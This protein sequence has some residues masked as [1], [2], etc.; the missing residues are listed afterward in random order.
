MAVLNPDARITVAKI[1]I[2]NQK[3][4]VGKTTTSLNLA[5]ALCRHGQTPLA[6]DLDPQAHLSA[7]AG[8]QVDNAEDSIYGF[9]NAQ[10]SLQELVRETHGG[11]HLIPAHV[12]LSKVDS[13]PGKGPQ[14]LHRLNSAI[15]RENLNTGR[16]IVIDC[17]PIL[18]M[19]SLNAIFA[20]D[21]ILVPVS[22]DWL[23]VKG[24]IQVDRTMRA[25]E[26]HVF[27][28]RLLRR[29]V[30]TRFDGRRRMSHAIYA[31]IRERFGD[32]LCDTKIS[33]NVSVAESPA[34]NEDVF[35]HA[36]GSRGAQDYDALH[37]ELQAA[38]FLS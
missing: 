35:A 12:E 18:G 33:E 36:P 13:Q 32:E 3:G 21:R 9:Y 34:A 26:Q 20:C 27:K 6:I 22:A 8:G 15:V 28:R 30:V 23:A 25:L 1:A 17:C 16:P 19:L 24:V 7:I 29:F 5:A 10:R 14:A 38:G 4:G 31:E 37:Q 11:W 2:F